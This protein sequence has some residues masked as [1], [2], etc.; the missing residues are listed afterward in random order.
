MIVARIT[1]IALLLSATV[2]ALSYLPVAT[3]AEDLTIP[4][5]VSAIL[6]FPLHLSAMVLFGMAFFRLWR[7]VIQ[8]YDYLQSF[9][10]RGALIGVTVLIYVVISFAMSATAIESESLGYAAELR[11]TLRMFSG[12][13]LV[14]LAGSWTVLRWPLRKKPLPAPTP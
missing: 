2:H 7:G 14:F 10:R 8:P 1:Q 6:M 12:I 3:S 4:L 13:W 9:S 5:A 11:H